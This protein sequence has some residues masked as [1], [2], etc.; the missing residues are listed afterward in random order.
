M[1]A[2]AK[3]QKIAIVT[4]VSNNYLHFAR[5]MLQSAGKHHPDA[6]LYCVIVDR[7]LS[8]ASG[9]AGEFEAISI[10]ALNLPLGEEFL[11]QYNILELNTAVKPWA[12]SHLINRG[13]ERVVYV[14]PDIYFYG[15]MDDA[16]RALEAG[17]D[18]LLTPHLLA[19]I[20][21]DKQPRELDIRRAGAY[22]FGFCALCDSPN[23]REFLS[24]WKSKLTRD[25][26]NDADRGLFVDQG[27]IDLVPGLFENVKILRHQGYNVAYWNIAQR[28][29]A[30][31]SANGYFID[32]DP[33]VFFHFSGLD[34]SEPETFSKHQA[35]F[36]LSTVGPAKELVEAYVR[37]VL[38][39]GYGRYRQLDYGYGRFSNGER[40][41]DVYRNLYRQSESLRQKMG[42]EP[43]T[44]FSAMSDPWPEICFEGISPTNAMV[45]LW[46]VRHD[47]QVEFP[48]NS[49]DSIIAYYRWFIHFPPGAQHFPAAVISRHRASVARFDERVRKRPN[50]LD[51]GQARIW[52]GNEQRA[53]RLYKYLL[54]RTPDQGGFLVYSDMCKTDAGFIRAWGEIGLSEESKKM[55][56][57]WLRMLNALLLSIRGVDRQSV[58][59]AAQIA[60]LKTEVIEQSFVGVFAVE[61]DI[62]TEG[63]WVTDRV[64]TPISVQP[65][66]RLRLEGI[67]F[68]ESI[69]KQTG[70]PESTLRF[71]LG[72]DEIHAAQINTHGNFMVECLVPTF[73]TAGLTNLVVE[74][75]KFFI[76]KNIGH[77]D[78]ERKLAWRMR[79]LSVENMPIFD[80]TNEDTFPAQASGTIASGASGYVSPKLAY[81]GFF[82]AD[83]DSEESGVWASA[84]VVLPVVPIEGEKILLRGTYFAKSIAKQTGDTESTLRFFMGGR[85]LHVAT[86]RDDGDFNLEFALPQLSEK[87]GDQLH[88]QCNNTFVRKDIGEGEDDRI[89]SWR[90]KL[91]T[92]GKITV[93]DCTRQNIATSNRR[94]VPR[95]KHTPDFAESRIKLFAFY[96]PQFS[97]FP[98][99]GLWPTGKIAGWDD[100]SNALPQYTDHHQPHLPIELG[101][102][103]YRSS[104]LLKRQVELARQYGI[105][106]F[107]FQYYWSPDKRPYDQ[108]LDRFLADAS[109]DFEFCVSW[110]IEETSAF[111]TET[112][113]A[114]ASVSDH[115][116][117]LVDSLVSAF[118]DK[119]YRKI[120]QK[121]V[122]IVAYPSSL[123]DVPN[124]VFCW[125]NRALQIGL[126]G[127]YL[128][129]CTVGGSS[130]ATHIEG[131][132]SVIEFPPYM[133]DE[134]THSKLSR[135]QP[136][137][138][139]FSGRV[140][141]YDELVSNPRSIVKLDSASFG[142]IM[143]SW[144][145]EVLAPGA[146]ISFADAT[147]EKYANWLSAIIAVTSE[148][149]PEEQLIFINAWNAW[150]EGA[151]MEPD[152]RHGYGYLHA[153]ATVLL[154]LP[155]ARNAE[156]IE[157]INKSFSKR[158]ETVVILH[159]FY[160]DLID[161]IFD[162][163]LSAA[164][165]QCDLIV[166]V[167][168]NI[169]IASLQKIKEKFANCLIIETENRGRDIRPFVIAFRKAYELG[170]LYACKLHTKKSL[171]RF[172]GDEWRAQLFDSLLSNTHSVDTVVRRFKSAPTIGI[173]APAQSLHDLG[174]PAA[175]AGNTAWLNVLLARMK[176]EK[177]IGR[178]DFSFPAGSMYWF[179]IT[180][181]RQLLDDD[182]VSPDE[183]ELEAGQLDG[184]LAHAI[185]RI[186]G[187]IP[188]RNNLEIGSL[189]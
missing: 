118:A 133:G 69:E 128:I 64:V 26:V 186:I 134:V 147:P 39:N 37:A 166:S 91:L 32:Q 56:F 188:A 125:R 165:R 55:R 169:S 178:Y 177:T 77:G 106:G 43:F 104:G 53:H 135:L 170:Y 54:H 84:N 173:L 184:T 24:W 105:A 44:R 176:D 187:R 68:P 45:A 189:K 168:Q 101:F 130:N 78:D 41:P 122:L 93:F 129:A 113:I 5:T 114:S 126:P 121:P 152:Q 137:N 38:T 183:F 36:T 46:N 154:N 112:A 7:D 13:Y 18:I 156:L 132:D 52:R 59:E 150:S 157:V 98:G 34:P 116:I 155:R 95:M 73:Q 141:D 90:I 14:D 28:Q 62:A 151:H 60:P 131:F 57:L 22:N 100:V 115:N 110:S 58:N 67:Y 153:T 8:H 11:F 99:N 16:L 108:P 109:L 138:P 111:V 97:R 80:C 161:T 175:Y 103:D 174:E 63:V 30:K 21:D 136:A 29:L 158:H 96:V 139:A 88:I 87:D 75:S 85:L 164:Q 142:A 23:T 148:K 167:M 145:S 140:Y 61:A 19:P 119:R 49:A 50:G 70:S 71:T 3:S 66:D 171:Q 47:V 146:G 72:S 182:F 35:R 74:S 81:S 6:A 10:G 25:C 17:T 143:P 160:E 48:L 172:D 185:E 2:A 149:R 163:Y 15:R 123:A 31:V 162:R 89:L 159:I 180:A 42:S 33:L 1:T 181:L 94:F 107:C 20:T 65:G 4:I 117:A 82:Q 179:R 120:D 79:S 86:L 124:T 92:A 102:Y 27:W 40:I 127:L 9:L 83:P 12:L 76:P 51:S 144:D